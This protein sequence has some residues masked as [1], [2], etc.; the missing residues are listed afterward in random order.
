MADPILGLDSAAT[1]TDFGDDPGAPARRWISVRVLVFVCTAAVI[2]SV[3][4]SRVYLGV[5]WPTDVLAGWPAGRL[6]AG[7]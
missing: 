3:G 1:P 2:F 4:V 7:R 5:H 6:G